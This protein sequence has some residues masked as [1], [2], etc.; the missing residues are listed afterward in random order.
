MGVAVVAW[1]STTGS[2]PRRTLAREICVCLTEIHASAGRLWDW[3]VMPESSPIAGTKFPETALNTHTS[4]AKP[5]RVGAKM[6]TPELQRGWPSPTL[7]HR[8]SAPTKPPQVQVVAAATMWTNLGVRTDR[9]LGELPHQIPLSNHLHQ[10]YLLGGVNARLEVWCGSGKL[11]FLI[12]LFIT[13][14]DMYYCPF[15]IRN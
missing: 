9:G 1:A 13:V 10:N 15:Y 12:L 3:V 8:G 6:L 2:P 4:T 14:K 5:Q 11:D 7:H